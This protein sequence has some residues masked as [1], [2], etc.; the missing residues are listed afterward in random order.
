[1]G[2]KDTTRSRDSLESTSS[3]DSTTPAREEVLPREYTVKT[4]VNHC[5]DRNGEMRYQVRWF[6]FSAAQ[7]TWEPEH[8]LPKE[9]AQ[10]YWREVTAANTDANAVLVSLPTPR[11]TSPYVEEVAPPDPMTPLRT[12]ARVPDLLQWT[13]LRRGLLQALL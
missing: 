5:V 8:H 9:V 11:S 6:G 12:C 7:D 3:Y 10:R 4:I 1:M 2:E 13:S